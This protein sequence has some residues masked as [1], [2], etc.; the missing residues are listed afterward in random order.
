[1]IQQN[2][3]DPKPIRCAIYTRKSTSEGLEQEFNT[4]D[5]QRLS[6]SNYIASQIGEG[7]VELE[8]RYDDGGFTG[9]NMERPALKRLLADIKAKKI[10]CV[11]VYK[12]D[13][14]SRSLLDFSRIMEQ[15]D[16][17]ECSFVSTTQHFNTTSSMGRLTLNILLSFAQFE[18][19]IISERTRDKMAAARRQGKYVG[20]RPL[21]GYNLDR[22]AKKLVVNDEEAGRVRQIF[23]LYLEKN[24]LVP[25]IE[26]INRRGWRTK[27]WTTKTGKTVGDVR[28][29]KNRLHCLLTNRIYLGQVCYH[30]EVYEGEHEGIVSEEAFTAVQRRLKKNRI[31]A[32]DTNHERRKGSLV[33][34]LR[35]TACDSA[36][37]QA[38]S[39]RGR[40]KPTYRYYVCSK[41]AKR[42]RK[43]CPRASLPAD[44]IELFV[45]QQLQSLT[46]DDSLL[47][48]VCNQVRLTLATKRNDL[49][50]E[51]RSL[52][53]EI[54]RTERAVNALAMPQEDS[55]PGDQRL[56]SLASLND[57]L[58]RHEKRL[59]ELDKELARAGKPLPNRV[60]ILKAVEDIEALWEKM[61]TGE[62]SRFM[63]LLVE[64][65][66]H[67]PREGNISI[68]L[69]PTGL[70]CLG[71]S[72]NESEVAQ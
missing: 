26:E 51:R 49:E 6:G 3:N 5:A 54:N 10:D 43:T 59:V 37:S 1:M 4:L 32:G 16:A 65:V 20:G 17:V 58:V 30:E 27:R 24:G 44:D 71:N 69:S 45:V 46:I 33:G 66:D 60:E 11:V 68:T 31:N 48:S 42:G 23:D 21:L 41:A 70:Q 7:W 36:M 72:D 28:F 8:E 64:R 29:C 40:G 39:G 55:D 35:C 47:N 61:T 13:R 50:K 56:E 2:E 38:T 9:G 15:F 12:V 63:S 14:L 62:R 18:R 53:G 22:E 19:E 52:V 67:D 34:L 25:T 57:Q